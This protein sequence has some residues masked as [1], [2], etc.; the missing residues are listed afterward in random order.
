MV[1]RLLVTLGTVEPLLA[2]WRADGDLGVEDVF[3]AVTSAALLENGGGRRG[4]MR[5]LT[6]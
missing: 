1:S 6:T 3:A 5:E 4:K 2:T